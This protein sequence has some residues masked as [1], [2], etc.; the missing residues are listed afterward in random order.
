MGAWAVFLVESIW[1][2]NISNFSLHPRKRW[3]IKMIPIKSAIFLY[4]IFSSFKGNVHQPKAAKPKFPRGFHIDILQ[5]VSAKFIGRSIWEDA[6]LK[7]LGRYAKTTT[8][9]FI[10][11]WLRKPQFHMTWLNLVNYKLSR[12]L[13]NLVLKCCFFLW[14]A[15]V[16]IRVEHLNL[17][18]TL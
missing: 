16:H 6:V 5:P 3:C 18:T 7:F 11:E 8:I 13:C 14:V 4:I 2:Y 12:L 17:R 15:A 10:G 1:G 9:K